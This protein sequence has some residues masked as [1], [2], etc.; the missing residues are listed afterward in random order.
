MLIMKFDEL[1][2]K[3]VHNVLICF[4]NAFSLFNLWKIDG[5]T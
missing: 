3:Q 4:R 2:G 5:K 1:R